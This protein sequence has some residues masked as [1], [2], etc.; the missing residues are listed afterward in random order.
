MGKAK[1][2]RT[3]RRQAQ[4]DSDNDFNY[5]QAIRDVADATPRG[6]PLD[7][8]SPRSQGIIAFKAEERRSLAKGKTPTEANANALVMG[9]IGMGIG[10]MLFSPRPPRAER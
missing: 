2:Q 6:E 7:L 4:D 1:Q 3:A 9:I 8:F 5:V 10:S